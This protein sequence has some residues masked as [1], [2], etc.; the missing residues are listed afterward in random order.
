MFSQS[1][2]LM[3]KAF[4]GKLSWFLD[5]NIYFENWKCQIF[6]NSASSCLTRYKRI[7]W[8][9][10]WD[11]KSYWNS[12]T[13]LW[14]STAVTTLLLTFCW[15]ANCTERGGGRLFEAGLRSVQKSTRGCLPPPCCMIVLGMPNPIRQPPERGWPPLMPAPTDSVE[16]EI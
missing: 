12:P 8:G 2:I 3:Q 4:S 10:H 14:N 16:P 9:A 5:Q 13:S 15:S 7:L 1:N 6:D 11:A